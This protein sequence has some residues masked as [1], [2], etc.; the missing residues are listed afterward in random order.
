MASHGPSLTSP[1]C[2]SH[3]GQNGLCA[4]KCIK[5][6]RTIRL[7]QKCFGEHKELQVALINYDALMTHQCLGSLSQK[8]SVEILSANTERLTAVCDASVLYHGLSATN[9]LLSWLWNFNCINIIHEI[10]H[11]EP[12]TTLKGGNDCML[13]GHKPVV[14]ST[15]IRT[16]AFPPF[17]SCYL[18][19]AMELL[20]WY[21]LSLIEQNQQERLT[22]SMETHSK[23]NITLSRGLDQTKK[24]YTCLGASNTQP[25][26]G[27]KTQP[28]QG[29]D[30]QAITTFLKDYQRQKQTGN[31]KGERKGKETRAERKGRE[32][33][34]KRWSGKITNKKKKLIISL[35][36]MVWSIKMERPIVAEREIGETG[37]FTMWQ[38]VLDVLHHVSNPEQL[39]ILN[40]YFSAAARA[41]ASEHNTKN[42]HTN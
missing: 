33:E 28:S 19:V 31:R 12:I 8:S 14:I 17:D 1:L 35:G 29:Q 25:S 38:G 21:K 40:K 10:I 16:R 9:M 13:P 20:L 3:Q 30:F 22:C 32:A 7:H 24:S 41:S 27:F 2:K 39:K 6:C 15:K 5:T 36:R 37:Y 34:K 42:L 26:L 18:G 23:E 11:T 4:K